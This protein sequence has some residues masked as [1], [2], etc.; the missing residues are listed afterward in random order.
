M[1]DFPPI[2]ISYRVADSQ[3]QANSLYL[4]L[5]NELGKGKVFLDKDHLEGGD[6]W[7]AELREKVEKA[8]VVLVVIVNRTRWLGVD[9]EGHRRIDNPKDWVRREVEE[10]LQKNEK[11]AVIPILFN[12][13]QI[14]GSLPDSCK[15]LSSRQGYKVKDESLKRDLA[16]LISQLKEILGISDE[17]PPPRPPAEPIKKTGKSA[18][19]F[20]HLTCN[21]VEQLDEFLVVFEEAP[22]KRLFFY[23]YG[24]ARQ[25]H[26]SLVERLSY[27]KAG[28][29]FDWET[30]ETQESDRDT[31][32][33]S[34]VWVK[35]QF[36]DNYAANR[37][38]LLNGLFE[39]FEVDTELPATER[40]ATELFASRYLQHYTSRDTLVVMLAIDEYSWSPEL[41]PKLVEEFVTVF[42][43]GDHPV[44]AP[45]ILFFFGIEYEK[46][47]SSKVREQVKKAIDESK[48]GIRLPELQP[49]T[50]ENVEE[51]FSRAPILIE[52]GKDEREMRARHFG[53]FDKK[54]MDEIIPELKK[55][56]DNHNKNEA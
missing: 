38:K 33:W 5:E 35:P 4:S 45:R 18:P 19:D 55:I 29:S 46:D 22:P 17:K 3:S 21:R 51:W 20:H 11:N 25:A 49:V 50:E 47:P 24:D 8:R 42:C 31:K 36:G 34:L 1:P 12:E 52:A 16:P 9:D 6:D 40:R 53:D 48:Y 56:I 54:D 23:L 37:I 27:E 28:K 14:P 32:K 26:Q 13:A 30:S 7:P 39:K 15:S 41:T 44:N 10:G 43:Q 2:F